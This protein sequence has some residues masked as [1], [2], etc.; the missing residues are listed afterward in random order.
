MQVIYVS[1]SETR[2]TAVGSQQAVGE[3]R[4]RGKALLGPLSMSRHS[5]GRDESCSPSWFLAG[6]SVYSRTCCAL[7][8]GCCFFVSRTLGLRTIVLTSARRSTRALSLRVSIYRRVRDSRQS[9]TSF[10]GSASGHLS[11]DTGELEPRPTAPLVPRTHGSLLFALFLA[12]IFRPTS[13][14]C[15]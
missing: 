7:L 13:Q 14:S 12:L 6:Q 8:T 4:F 2:K 3:A 9:F 11:A 15:A 10:T 5:F 1:P